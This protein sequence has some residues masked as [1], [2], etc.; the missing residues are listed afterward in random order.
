MVEEIEDKKDTTPKKSIFTQLKN[1]FKKSK[2][3]VFSYGSSALE[4]YIK[5]VFGWMSGLSWT[6]FSSLAIVSTCA[7]IGTENEKLAL[8]N[9]VAASYGIQKPQ[10]MQNPY[11]NQGNVPFIPGSSK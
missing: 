4:K 5:P 11:E 9:L 10:T 1:M 3:S 7:I 8:C 2:T 6:L